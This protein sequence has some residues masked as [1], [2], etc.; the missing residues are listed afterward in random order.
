MKKP[1]TAKEVLL[2]EEFRRKSLLNHLPNQGNFGGDE[3]MEHAEKIRETLPKKEGI[4]AVLV[5]L[6][7]FVLGFVV[8]MTFFTHQ[9]LPLL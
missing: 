1:V 9:V 2:Y 5:L 3:F 4:G 8:A 6:V 7:V